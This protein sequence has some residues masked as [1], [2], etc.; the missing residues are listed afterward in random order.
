MKKLLFLALPLLI[1]ACRQDPYPLDLQRF[2]VAW[3]DLDDSGTR[4]LDDEL[5]FAVELFTTDPDTDDQVIR[6][7]EFTYTVN[8]AFAGVLNGDSGLAS[9]NVNMNGTVALERLEKPGPGDLEP[10]DRIEF[11]FWARDNWGTEVDRRYQVVI[12]D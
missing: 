2:D 1:T 7:W 9:N 3:Y 8:G 5:D 10:G 12:E 4:T 6:E 11:R